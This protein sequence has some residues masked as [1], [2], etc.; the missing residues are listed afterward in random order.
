MTFSR[1]NAVG[2]GLFEVLTSAQ[3][4][5]LDIDHTNALDGL[6]AGSYDIGANALS[7]AGSGGTVTISTTVFNV[8]SASAT[9]DDL[10]VLTFEGNGVGAGGTTINAQAGASLQGALEVDGTG[11]GW[12]L[13]G[14]VTYSGSGKVVHNTMTELGATSHTLKS[15]ASFIV[16]GNI[17]VDA[18]AGLS[19]TSGGGADVLSGGTLTVQSGGTLDCDAGSAVAIQSTPTLSLGA[20][21]TTGG[22]LSIAAAVAETHSNTPTFNDG[23]DVVGTIDCNIGAN[24][25]IRLQSKELTEGA[26][27]LDVKNNQFW[28][29]DQNWSTANTQTLV[30]GSPG[31]WQIISVNSPFTQTIAGTGLGAGFTMKSGTTGDVRGALFV[32]VDAT[33]S[34]TV[35]MKDVNP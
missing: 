25:H 33:N 14:D 19:I 18:S 28:Y 12:V 35:L 3:M 29:I 31:D 22:T 6:N 4:N 27:S 1:V 20:T 11:L 15:G 26:N 21:F 13:T 7:I 23:M 32:W 2:W 5:A 17:S 30:D 34:W 10:T 9:Y 24:G 8:D 16:D